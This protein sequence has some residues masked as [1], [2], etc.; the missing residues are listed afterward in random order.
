VV[1]V[2]DIRE[3][4]LAMLLGQ[5]WLGMMRPGE[6]ASEASQQRRWQPRRRRTFDAGQAAGAALAAGAA[7]LGGRFLAHLAWLATAGALQRRCRHVVE[8]PFVLSPLAVVGQK[9]K[10]HDSRLERQYKQPTLQ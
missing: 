9:E 10:P 7:V 8:C 2:N 6:R 4:H 5:A 1:W 3:A